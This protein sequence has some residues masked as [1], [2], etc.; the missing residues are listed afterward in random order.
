[1]SKNAPVALLLIT[2]YSLLITH[3]QTLHK[4]VR[5]A[6]NA[7]WCQLNAKPAYRKELKF[8]ANSKSHLKMTKYP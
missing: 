1:M 6:G 3:H 5:N 2:Y 4:L 8:L 7:Y